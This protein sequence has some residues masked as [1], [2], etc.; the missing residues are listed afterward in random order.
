MTTATNRGRYN[1]TAGGDLIATS[2]TTPV[3]RHRTD[4]DGARALITVSLSGTWVGTVTLQSSPPDAELWDTVP[5]AV[6]TANTRQNVELGGSMD[7]RWIF[8]SRT[9]G[10]ASGWICA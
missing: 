8:T 10:T 3:Y 6:F 2:G 4:T 9:S 5:G 1:T 7:Y